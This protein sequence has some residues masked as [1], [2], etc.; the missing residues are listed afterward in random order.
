M[1]HDMRDPDLI[2]FLDYMKHSSH[3]TVERHARILPARRPPDQSVLNN[4]ALND[5]LYSNINQSV[6]FSRCSHKF[7]AL[8]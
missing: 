2:A 1:I 7:A 6:H 8:H 5:L 4:I 3:S